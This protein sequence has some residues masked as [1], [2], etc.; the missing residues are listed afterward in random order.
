MTKQII[1]EKVLTALKQCHKM[2]LRG[3]SMTCSNCPYKQHKDC[4][5]RMLNDTI[6]LIEHLDEVSAENFARYLAKRKDWTIMGYD[7]KEMVCEVID[8]DNL[9]VRVAEFYDEVRNGPT[10]P[11]S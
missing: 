4:Y 10:E 7:D 5:A 2:T 1:M 3:E 11:N 9:P 8:I 6:Y